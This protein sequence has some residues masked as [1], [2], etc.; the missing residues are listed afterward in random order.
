MEH[1]RPRVF[2]VPPRSGQ[3]GFPAAWLQKGDTWPDGKLLLDAP[4]EVAL[5]AGISRRLDAAKGSLS[6]R[7]VGRRAGLSP[8][9]VS[10]ILTGRTWGDV[11]SI[12][13]LER[14]LGVELWGE[15]HTR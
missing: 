4:G 12:A 3:F 11:L 5:A 2:H 6:I 1:L 13:R 9:T 15:E 8:Q 14:A 7:E 10:N